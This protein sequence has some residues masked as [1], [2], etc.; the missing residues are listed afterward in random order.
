MAWVGKLLNLHPYACLFIDTTWTDLLLAYKDVVMARDR[1][2]AQLRIQRMFHP[3]CV[4]TISV[5]TALD[6]WLR[7]KKFPPGSEISTSIMILLF[8]EDVV[9]VCARRTRAWP[10][11]AL[12]IFGCSPFGQS[13]VSH[14]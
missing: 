4:V 7:V 3:Q 2:A 14:A 12:W 8:G 13:R 9:L 10:G 11:F 6:L 1:E 5:R